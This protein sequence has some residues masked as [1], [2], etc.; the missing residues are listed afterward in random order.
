MPI[1][2]GDLTIIYTPQTWIE[3]IKGEI[4]DQNKNHIISQKNNCQ[5]L[6]KRE[7][8]KRDEYG[9]E[10]RDDG[11]GDGDEKRDD[12][13]KDGNENP[14]KITFVLQSDYPETP[15][16]L[17]V[18]DIPYVN[19]INCCKLSRIKEAV[20][21]YTSAYRP[22]ANCISC[23]SILTQVN[24]STKTRFSHIL[25]ENSKIKKMKRIIKYDIAITEI[26]EI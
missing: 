8:E 13:D 3:W 21:K 11:L 20:K 25:A 9:D 14:E 15:P 7:Q 16:H 23:G 26:A 22:Y 24:W 2:Y 4:K 6:E 1:K 12:G 10:K 5:I 17:Y 18:N 19:V